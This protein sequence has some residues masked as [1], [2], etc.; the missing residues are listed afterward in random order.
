MFFV[1]ASGLCRACCGEYLELTENERQRR[2][3]KRIYRNVIDVFDKNNEAMELLNEKGFFSH[4]ER[5]LSSVEE[6]ALL[7]IRYN[8]NCYITKYSIETP[9]KLYGDLDEIKNLLKTGEAIKDL[10]DDQ[11]KWLSNRVDCLLIIL[12]KFGVKKKKRKIKDISLSPTKT[13]PAADDSQQQ[14]SFTKKTK[15]TE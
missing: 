9:L 1:G 2:C 5:L 7:S 14:V 3:F 15:L 12:Q 8:E 11:A 6:G 13:P 4:P 10:D